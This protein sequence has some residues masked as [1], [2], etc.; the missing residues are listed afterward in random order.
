[1]TIRSLVSQ[2][3]SAEPAMTSMFVALGKRH[4]GGGFERGKSKPQGQ[5]R[6]YDGTVSGERDLVAAIAPLLRKAVKQAGQDPAVSNAAIVARRMEE[7]ITIHLLVVHPGNI[8]QG[9]WCS[10][11]S[12][13]EEEYLKIANG[14][15]PKRYPY[16]KMPSPVGMIVEMHEDGSLGEP[17]IQTLAENVW[18][19][20]PIAFST[21]PGARV[22]LLVPATL[23]RTGVSQEPVRVE[24]GCQDPFWS[25]LGYAIGMEPPSLR[26]IRRIGVDNG[27]RDDCGNRV[28]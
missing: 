28:D 4:G 12:Y 23:D 3:F 2:A 21:L 18:I 1:M 26:D 20:A 16:K 27:Y 6:C 8:E 24:D 11:E 25:D 14:P 15:E 17:V 5:S 7:G 22:N 13:T 10:F 9:Q 19:D